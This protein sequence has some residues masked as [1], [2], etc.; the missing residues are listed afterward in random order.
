[1]SEY[2]KFADVVTPR[3]DFRYWF[4]RTV[5]N[6]V[7]T[8]KVV[9]Q[10]DD[11]AFEPIICS[12]ADGQL[13]PLDAQISPEIQADFD[14]FVSTRPEYY[15]GA[16]VSVFYT[17]TIEAIDANTRS[18][19]QM[20][21]GALLVDADDDKELARIDK[22]LGWLHQTDFYSTPA[23]TR[24]HDAHK[25]GLVKHHLVVANETYDLA[26]TNAFASV[27]IN[28]A[29]INA[30]VH[31]WCKVGKYNTYMRN[32]KND[33]TNKW[34]KVE[35]FGYVDEPLEEKGHGVD[36]AVWALK[37]LRINDEQFDAIRW[38]MG[39]WN[40]SDSELN[41]LQ[42][43]NQKYPMVHLLQFADQLAITQYAV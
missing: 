36:S 28:K 34:E 27:D 19:D 23:S 15:F 29:I 11:T 3:I 8:W 38:H 33:Q 40:V 14:K 1:M 24:Y 6:G 25:G 43:C 17:D 20:F 4:Y 41:A 42:Q 37:L 9:S 10:S 7:C 22:A 32:V 13:V 21:A 18:Y 30:L 26:Q 16:A 35:S 31:D 2:V 39:R 5:N 12:E